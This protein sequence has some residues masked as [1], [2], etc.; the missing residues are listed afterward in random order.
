MSAAITAVLIGAGL[1]ALAI[2]IEIREGRAAPGD[3]DYRG[4]RKS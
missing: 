2:W 3:G 1:L 4:P